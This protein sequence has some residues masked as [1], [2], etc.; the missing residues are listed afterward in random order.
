MTGKQKLLE[1]DIKVLI[2]NHLKQRGVINQDTLIM[3]ELTIGSHIRRVDLAILTNGKLIGFEIK[4]EAD[5]LHRID[6]QI[7]TY[8]NYFHKVIV[9][10]D[11]KF[12][13]KL[14]TKLPKAV[15]IWEIS[16][17]KI[18]VANKGRSSNKILT[19]YLID[20]LDVTD[21]KKLASKL[22]IK[23]GHKRIF[24]QAVLAEAPHTELKKSAKNAI[25]RKFKDSSLLFLNKTKNKKITTKDL[26]VLSR[27][28]AQREKT[29][30]E[31]IKNN[32]F[33][34]N[35]DKHILHLERYANSSG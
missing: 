23:T 15:G 27:F 17:K 14:K 18:K 11:P 32:L 30:N 16:N 3:N 21:L 8:L 10:T 6:G 25:C 9:V 28:K 26:Q 20:Y 13:E 22:N 31:K 24:L 7:E 12:L 33:W 5:S 2:L 35:L 4:S 1:A 29:H 34:Q 19:K